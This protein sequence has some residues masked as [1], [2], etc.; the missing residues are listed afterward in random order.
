MGRVWARL[1][2]EAR[3]LADESFRR[4][5]AVDPAKLARRVVHASVAPED[6]T[7]YQVVLEEF[8]RVYAARQPRWRS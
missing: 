3:R 4:G 2:R 1:E 7:E 6:V 5:H 8:I